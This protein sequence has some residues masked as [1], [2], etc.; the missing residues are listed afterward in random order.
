M[1][2]TTET[3]K[4]IPGHEDKYEASDKGRI[5]SI[6]PEREYILSPSLHPCGTLYV[7]LMKEGRKVGYTV[8][9]LVTMAFHGP[10]PHDGSRAVRVRRDQL[11]NTPGNLHWD[12]K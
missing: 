6:G 1:S 8:G 9:R 4:T 2:S 10:A 11:D 7:T 3:W 5:R 12:S